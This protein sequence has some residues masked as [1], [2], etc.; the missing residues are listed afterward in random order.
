MQIPTHFFTRWQYTGIKRKTKTDKQR[1]A[2]TGGVDMITKEKLGRVRVGIQAGAEVRTGLLRVAEYGICL[3]LSALCTGAELFGRCSPLGLAM[4]AA[5]GAGGRGFAALIG[6][7]SGYLFFFGVEGGLH[8]IAA[9]VLCYAIAFA[10]FETPLGE[11]EW[12]MPSVAA[13]LLG[14]CRFIYLSGSGFGSSELIFFLSEPPILF[15]A[16]YA[17]RAL[18][19][20][21]RAKRSYAQLEGEER[22]ALLTLG[23]TLLMALSAVLL[24]G[25]FSLGRILAAVAVMALSK[26][27]AKAGLLAGISVGLTMDLCS[28]RAPYYSMIYALAGAACGLAAKRNRFIVALSY[29]LAS[30]AA[31]LWTWEAGLRLS[32]LYEVLAAVPLFLLLPRRLREQTGKLLALEAPRSGDWEGARDLAVRH[33]RETARAFRALYESIRESMR[34]LKNT[35]DPAQVFH[36]AAEKSCKSCRLRELCWQHDYQ[37]TQQQL[38]DALPQLLERGKAEN[39]DFPPQFRSRCI[40]FPA[41]LAATNEELLA[42]LYRRRYQGTLREHRAALCQQYAEVDRILEK[43]AM[44]IAVEFTPDLPRQARLRHYLRG[45]GL[46][47]MGR[48]YY[49]AQ[50]H[51]RVE[52]PAAAHLRTEDG[53]R[54]LGEALSVSLRPAEELGN[55]ALLFPQA[56]PLAATAGVSGRSKAGEGV[57]GD[58][59]TWFRREDGLLCI[60]LCDGMGSGA[61]ARQE[62][63]LAVRLLQNFLKAGVAPELALAT[64]NSALTLRGEEG[65]GCS[66]VDLLTVELYSGQCGIY[67]LG[68]APT[69]LCRAGK[70]S[71]LAGASLPAGL[72]AGESP[73][74]DKLQ[75]R[76]MAGDW[77]VLLSDG[78]LGGE[79][80]AW[81][82]AVL[83]NYAGNSPGELSEQITTAAAARNGEADDMTVIALRLESKEK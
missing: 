74:P 34:P 78:V 5:A 3:L 27:G 19:T 48:V 30:T 22:F 9:A 14:I 32:L 83:E 24:M 21:D 28:G 36:R 72:C 58:T 60:L 68:A 4:V 6:A 39:S 31:V 43:A 67:K 64:L 70:V 79:D 37:T 75:K 57:S 15:A 49:D 38:G 29:L 44:E 7:V 61:A 11:K 47:E 54:R 35:E 25:E 50:G 77:L 51:L 52:T 59:G 23:A 65:G 76:A 82:R 56:E 12:F 20:L 13:L 62:S 26:A 71:T 16:S 80:D 66:T 17:Y 33:V 46:D 2:V 81:L 55:G 8:Y 42:L 63:A 41:Y 18:F 10:V 45:R 40:H 1:F 53:R 73:S 69:Y